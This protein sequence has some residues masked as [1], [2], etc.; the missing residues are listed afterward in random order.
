MKDY[1]EALLKSLHEPTSRAPAWSVQDMISRPLAS[2]KPLTKASETW[3]LPIPHGSQYASLEALTIDVMDRCQAAGL[4][5]A[6][7]L[8]MLKQ[9]ALQF[10]G[11]ALQF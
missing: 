11:G 10:E 5:L 9:I 1:K 3:P 4:S 6:T 8:R 2:V 7:T